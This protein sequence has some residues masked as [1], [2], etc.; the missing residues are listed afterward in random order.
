MRSLV[1]LVSLV[2]LAELRS[3]A[4]AR[5]TADLAIDGVEAQLAQGRALLSAGKASEAQVLF[6]AAAATDAQ[7]LRTRQ[8]VIRS[9]LP[10]GRVNDALDAIDALAK[11]GAKGPALDYLYGMAFAFKG[12]EYTQQNVQGQIIDMAFA[13]AVSYLQKAT[14]ADP[15]LYK[16]AF[17]ALAEAAW[18]Q[19]KLDVARA[20]AEKAVALDPASTDASMILGRIAL[21]QFVATKEDEAKQAD[22]D[23]HWEA[24]RKAFDA[25]AAGLRSAP[26]RQAEAAAALVELGHTYVW[27]KQLDEAA[28]AYGEALGRDPSQVNYAQV[29]STLDGGERFLGALENGAAEFARTHA[30]ETKADS[31]LLWWLGWAR[32]DQKKYAEAEQAFTR[33]FDKDPTFQNCWY[34]IALTR[35]QRK[36]YEGAVQALRRNWDENM[37]DLVGSLSSSAATNLA[38][39]DYLVGWCAQNDRTFEAGL[40]SEMQANTSPKTARYWN[41]MGLFYRDAGEPLRKSTK[42]EDHATAQGYFETAYRAYSSAH[43][44]TPDDPSIMNDLA[45]MLHY[46]LDREL[47]RAAELYKRATER[48]TIELARTDLPADLRSLYEVALRDSKNNLAKLEAGKRE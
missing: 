22:A 18:F 19:Q 12:R 29:L 17:P 42:E 6:E 8:W 15:V 47:E 25:A 43:E 27:K 2:A 7:S 46:Y 9:W 16:D 37:N 34:Y 11:E 26:D 32:Y 10:Q 4:A 33:A 39:L 36:D 41:N 45:V 48:A 28:R 30:P 24:A 5:C 3:P 23:K 31:G 44:L 40:L 38:I 1:L 21:S 13:D 20:A 14:A 35:Y